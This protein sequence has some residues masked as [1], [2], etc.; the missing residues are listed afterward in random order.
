MNRLL[1]SFFSIL[2]TP[3]YFGVLA[4]TF[5]AAVGLVLGLYL[6]FTRSNVLQR[7]LKRLTLNQKEPEQN[8]KKIRLFEE[9]QQGFV[10][11]IAKPLHNVVAPAEGATK[12]KLRLK[13]IQAGFRSERA[14][15][16]YLAAKVVGAVVFPAILVGTRFF[17]GFNAEA[18]ALCLVLALAG[19]LLP[20]LFL[21]Y[22]TKARQQRIVKALP[23]ALD[24]MVVCVEAG[25][26]LDMTFKRI[27]EEIRPMNQDL[28]DEFFLTNLEIRGGRPRHESLKN[29]ALRTGISE[30]NALMTILVQTARFGTSLAKSL[31]VHADSMRVKRRQMAEEKAAKAAVKLLFPLIF[32]I[33]PALFV[34]LVGPAAIKIVTILFPAMSGN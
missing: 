29:M 22:L 24:L 6:L 5:L 23:D 1:N 27:G 18:A 9:E 25:L 2:E 33:F 30:I 13:L 32:F 3:E 11:K 19:F 7:R 16:N 12:K 28:S 34:V 31:R 17:Y 4:M 15:Q 26:G 20:N 8:K 14:Y 21:H 10:G